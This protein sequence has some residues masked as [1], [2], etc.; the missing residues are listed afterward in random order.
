MKHFY[1][2]I[3]K[4]VLNIIYLWHL[5]IYGSGQDRVG[6]RMRLALKL[7]VSSR[8][9]PGIE[10]MTSRMQ[11]K[12]SINGSTDSRFYSFRGRLEEIGCGFKFF[13]LCHFSVLFSLWYYVSKSILTPLLI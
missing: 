11:S 6:K 5:L 9:L 1:R 3:C 13:L 4:L 8:Y 7:K 10:T 2:K 12:R